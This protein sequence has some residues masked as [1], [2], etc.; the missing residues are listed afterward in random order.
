MDDGRQD[1]INLS[2]HLRK[3]SSACACFRNTPKIDPGELLWSS[4]VANGCVPR[5]CPVKLL[6]L[7]DAASN[8]AVKLTVEGSAVGLLADI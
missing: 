2:S 7:F 4:S 5:L 6:Y 8:I 3:L 1:F